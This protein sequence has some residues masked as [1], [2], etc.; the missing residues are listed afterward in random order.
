MVWAATTAVGCASIGY[1]DGDP[2]TNVMP[3]QQ[4]YVCNYGPPGNFI[5]S[6][7]YVVDPDALL[8]TCP[9]SGSFNN[10]LTMG[11]FSNN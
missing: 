3:Y 10:N 11:I 6:P 5:G 8:S 7:V 2:D 4:L 1:T 9:P